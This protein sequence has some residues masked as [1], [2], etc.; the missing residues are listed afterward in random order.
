MKIGY[1]LK[2]I[3]IINAQKK[4]ELVPIPQL[5]EKAYRRLMGLDS[6]QLEF[7]HENF[8]RGGPISIT[9]LQFPY[10]YA[11]LSGI[12]YFN[13]RAKLAILS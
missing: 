8:S 13:L 5:S 9:K 4:L 7:A 3:F 1:A 2:P 6:P 10:T 12:N 11:V